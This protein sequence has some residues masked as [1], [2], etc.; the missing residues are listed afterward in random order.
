M[1]NAV[2]DTSFL[3]DWVK[4]NKNSLIFHIFDLI[5][6]TESVLSEIRN[7]KALLWISA[8]L[9]SNRI[10]ILPELPDIIQKANYLVTE[11]RRLPVRPLDFPES[12]CLVYG[13][14][15]NLVVLTENGAAVV[16]PYFYNEYKDVK[17]MRAL[18]VLYEL[19][20]QGYIKDLRNEITI[21]SEETK[22][23]FAERDLKRYNLI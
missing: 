1:S 14:V 12:I 23:K 20:K 2:M 13:K 15:L 7:E 6:I 16:A 19:Y 22:H 4:Y 17:V 18:D 5:Y 11:S 10:A 21:Y 3:L 8:N 9:E